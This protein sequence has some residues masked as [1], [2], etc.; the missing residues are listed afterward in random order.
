MID[1]LF[2]FLSELEPLGENFEEVLNDNLW[3]L[4]VHTDKETHIKHEHLWNSV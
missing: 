3:E 4:M 2:D 1:D